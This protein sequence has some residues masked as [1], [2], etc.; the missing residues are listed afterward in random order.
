[1]ETKE[2]LKVINKYYTCTNEPFALENIL[3]LTRSFFKLSAEFKM[4][5]MLFNVYNGQDAWCVQESVNYNVV[6]FLM[7]TST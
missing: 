5:I 3:L 6:S 2:K 4:Y 7:D 1:M